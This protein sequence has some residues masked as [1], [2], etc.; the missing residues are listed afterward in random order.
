MKEDIA[1]YTIFMR[2]CLE[3]AALGAG[4][5]APNPM[6]GAVLVYDGRII[7]E[8]YHQRYGEAHAE[9]NAIN[10][11]I[12]NGFADAISKSVIYVS[13]EPC[14]HFGKTPPCADLIIHHKIPKVVIGCRDPF[15]EVDGKGIEKLQAAG[16]EV[17]YGV[18]ESECRE[19]NKRFFTFHTKHRPYVILKWAQTENRK[20]AAIGTERL[21]ITNEKT[22]RLVHKW[23]GE[24]AGI[25]IGTNTAA[26]DN[27]EL[28]TRLWPG[29]SPTRLVIDMNLR[30][31]S[32]LK[33]FNSKTNTILFNKVKHG[34]EGNILFY[35]VTDDVSVAQQ[36]VNA[37]YQL[38][39]QS[40]IIEGGA[41]LLQSFIEEQL[42]DEARIITNTT[43]KIE[44]GLPAPQLVNAV[45]QSADA[46]TGDGIN[47]FKPA[48]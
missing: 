23:R 19:T 18:M 12:E 34:Q 25:L 11:A 20:I 30:L 27:P 36:V 24:E 5:T 42:W 43:M 9:V 6:V 22:N 41:V 38:K 10:N 8:G 35:Q 15:K 29:N 1:D 2:R 46:S 37:L 4:N 21:L 32:S 14:A 40:V 7:G 47:I 39:I 3:L 16:I 45:E 31:P 48:F 33:I 28:T 13:L 44:N 17:V 26:S